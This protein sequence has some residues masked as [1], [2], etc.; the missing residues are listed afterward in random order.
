MFQLFYSGHDQGIV[1]AANMML[2]FRPDVTHILRCC[3]LHFETVSLCMKQFPAEMS[4]LLQSKENRN[5]V[6]MW[7]RMS[8]F[9]L[10]NAVAAGMLRIFAS[11]ISAIPDILVDALFLVKE[12]MVRDLSDPTLDID[13]Y[14]LYVDILMDF[15]LPP[16]PDIP[17]LGH[18]ALSSFPTS[19]IERFHSNLRTLSLF[20]QE[21]DEA[22]EM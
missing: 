4:K 16:Y 21:W 19:K 10:G 12:A 2:R 18:S 1:H 22:C 11:P 17:Q 20:L 14:R 7:T 9:A 15:P 6:I 3:K 5:F 8:V 13:Q